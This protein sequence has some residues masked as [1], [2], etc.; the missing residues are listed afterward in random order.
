MD[1]STHSEDLEFLTLKESLQ[2]RTDDYVTHHTLRHFAQ[3]PTGKAMCVVPSLQVSCLIQST[4]S[5]RKRCES[6]P[7]NSV[8]NEANSQIMNRRPDHQQ[9]KHTTTSH[10]IP[11]GGKLRQTLQFSPHQDVTLNYYNTTM[12]DIAKFRAKSQLISSGLTKFDDLPEHNTTKDGGRH[13]SIQWKKTL[14]LST[15]EEMDLLFKWLGEDS[16]EQALRI[17]SVNIRQP[18]TCLKCNIERTE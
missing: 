11:P 9:I 14:E 12:A 7:E 6:L 15:T 10:R 5:R 3:A 18:S 16:S 1:G 13:S 4:M 17:R 2:K 8:Q